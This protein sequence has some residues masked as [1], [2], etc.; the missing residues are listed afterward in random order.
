MSKKPFE[1]FIKNEPTGAKKKEIFR[2]EKKKA[3]AESRA[4]GEE[5]R[6]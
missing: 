1:K 3:K 6:R 5:I 4:V 2:Q